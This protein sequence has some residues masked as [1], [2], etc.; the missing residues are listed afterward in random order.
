MVF[1]TCQSCLPIDTLWPYPLIQGLSLLMLNLS[2]ITLNRVAFLI[3]LQHCSIA[4]YQNSVQAKARILTVH[5]VTIITQLN[6]WHFICC[7][8]VGTILTRQS[9]HWGWD[10]MDTIS[11]M[12]FSNE[13]SWMKMFRFLLKIQWSL[14]PRF[15]L[16]IFQH[17]LR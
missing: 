17:W 9:R 8:L 10:K 14:M 7:S 5:A 12:T 2:E 6:Y 16:T 3:I 15:Q 13:F 11:Q 1:L 4:G